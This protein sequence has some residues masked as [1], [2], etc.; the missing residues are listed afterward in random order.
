MDEKIIYGILSKNH[1][2]GLSI[3]ELVGISSIP[4]SKIR[5]IL[6]KFEGADIVKIRKVGMAKLYFIKKQVLLENEKYS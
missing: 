4:R 6:A 2:K 3:T 1:E 5:I